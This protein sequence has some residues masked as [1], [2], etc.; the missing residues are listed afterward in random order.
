VSLGQSPDGSVTVA[1][2]GAAGQVREAERR[3]VQYRAANRQPEVCGRDGIGAVVID[4][5]RGDLVVVASPIGLRQVYWTVSANGLAVGA[6]PAALGAGPASSLRLQSLYE[7][8]YFHMLPGPASVFQG[9]EKLDGGHRLRW[10]GSRT[11]ITRYWRPAFHEEPP[12]SEREATQHLHELLSR[13]VGRCLEDGAP[14][15]AF[16]SGG[17]DSSTVAGMAAQARPGLPTVSMG[18]D[19]QGYD[20][21]EYARIAARRFTTRPLEYYVTPE[22]LLTTLPEIAAAFAEPFGN[23]SA[24]AAYHCA[25]I[26]REHGLMR[27]LA[28]DGGDEI[29]GGNERYAKQ[30][31]LERYGC[32]PAAIRHGLLEPGVNAAARI[33]RA[34][35]IGKAESYIQQAQVPLP[36]RLQSYNFLHRHDPAEVFA[37]EVLAGVDRERPLR[38]LRDEYQAPDA[39]NPIDRMLF[40]DWKFTLHDNDLVKVNSMCAMAGIEVA[41]PMLDQDLVEFTLGLP[42]EWKVRRGELRWFYKRAM[43][44]FL[45]DEIIAKKKHGF[46]LPFGAWMRTH[47]G[48]RKLAED[49]LAELAKRRLFRIQFLHE[50]LRMHRDGH[51]SY[52]GELVWILTMLELWLQAHH[53]ATRL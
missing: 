44:G 25:R 34:F 7:Y 30:M 48:L 35:P 10:D 27:L 26:A 32:V 4:Q 15:G 31:V 24:A 1:L 43:R 2:L 13:A 41:Y 46:G 37:D 3:A 53:P 11:E 38:L 29:F 16:L 28:G 51:A 49:A 36:D 21:M 20:E 17:L 9:I 12:P 39:H 14:S 18:F 50:A 40:L 23:S 22:D 33:T 45:P 42:A 6:S 5:T 47:D 19:V 8:V 52:Y